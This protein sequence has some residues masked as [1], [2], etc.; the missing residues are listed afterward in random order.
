M[1]VQSEF[2]RVA[3]GTGAGLSRNWSKRK[4]LRRSAHHRIQIRCGRNALD[5]IRPRTPPA[6]ATTSSSKLC[7]VETTRLHGCNDNLS[8]AHS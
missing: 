3:V 8:A 2:V 1:D 4:G 6:P 5:Q 7:F